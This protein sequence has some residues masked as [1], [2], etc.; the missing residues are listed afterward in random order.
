[1]KTV[2]QDIVN[3]VRDGRDFRGGHC[4]GR[5]YNGQFLSGYRDNLSWHESDFIYLLWNNKIAFG[6]ASDKTISVTDCG[7]PTA[8]TVSRLNAI[9]A[10][11][12]VPV[13]ARIKNKLTRYI[14]VDE[15]GLAEIIHVNCTDKKS[16]FKAGNWTISVS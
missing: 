8:T 2:D 5:E 11:L 6:N 3:A 10:G 9:F 4:N 14:I 7:Y 13:T 12:D 16:V 15:D 1:M